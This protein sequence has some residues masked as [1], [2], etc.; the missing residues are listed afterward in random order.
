MSKNKKFS[1]VMKKQTNMDATVNYQRIANFQ[2]S[3]I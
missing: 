3:Q 2:I 1:D